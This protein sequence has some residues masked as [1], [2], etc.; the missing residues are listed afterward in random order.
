MW[1]TLKEHEPS[2]FGYQTVSLFQQSKKFVHDED[3]IKAICK[4]KKKEVFSSFPDRFQ[5]LHFD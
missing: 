3:R 5:L 4:K 1:L 2:N